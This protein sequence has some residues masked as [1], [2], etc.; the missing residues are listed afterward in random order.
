VGRVA[1]LV[2]ALE[3]VERLALALGPRLFGYQL[4]VEARLRNGG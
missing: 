2:W 1:P 4:L 3:R